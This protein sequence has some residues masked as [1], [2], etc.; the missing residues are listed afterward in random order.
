[1]KSVT[2]MIVLLLAPLSMAYG[3]DLASLQAEAIKNRQVIQRYQNNLEK[4]ISDERIAKSGYYP[5][6][7][8]A[9]T[10]NALDEASLL[11]DK[12]NSVFYSALSLN[13]FAGFK[14]KYNIKSASLLRQVESYKLNG[15]EQ[16]IKRN[17]ALKYLQVY[18]RQANLKARQDTYNTLQRVYEDGEKRNQVGLIDNNALLKFKVDLNFA[19]IQVKT[20]QAELDKSLLLLRRETNSTVNLSELS[21][22]EFE[23]MPELTSYEKSE[24]EMLERRSEIKVLNEMVGIYESQAE[25]ARAAYYPQ[26]DFTASYQNYDND[27]VNGAGDNSVEESRAQLVLSMNLFSGFSSQQT[28]AKME[29]EQR[30]A[31]LDLI[32]LKQDLK[33]G[34]KSLYLDYK[35]SLDTVKA[36]LLNIEQAK[37]NLRITRLKYNEGLQTESELLDAVSTLSRA[38]YNH[39]E[40]VMA[41]YSNYYGILR[42]VEKL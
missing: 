33:A 41:L 15:M 17:V 27:Y 11:E 16:D 22:Q 21:F 29:I 31:A 12:E 23:S 28:I 2:I 25:M 8:I 13:L 18:G 36:A 24:K 7:N 5:S 35:V 40:V 34:L 10:A 14:D 19:A 1:M 37:E 26:L 3:V 30:S 9:Y 6:V 42:M 20:A 38:D 39:V 32:E 4:S